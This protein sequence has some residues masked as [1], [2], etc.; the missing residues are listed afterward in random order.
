VVRCTDK[1]GAS[2]VVKASSDTEALAHE[3]AVMA[4]FAAVD[5]APEV[6]LAA[7]DLL[8]MRDMGSIELWDHPQAASAA[9]VAALVQ[10][11]HSAQIVESATPLGAGVAKLQGRVIACKE[12]DIK[13]RRMAGEAF[14][15]LAAPADR[16]LLHGDLHTKNV[17]VSEAGPRLIDPY[18]RTGPAIYDLV[19][20]SIS[21]GD[22]SRESLDELL[23]AY[24]QASDVEAWYAWTCVS[25]LE[26]A[27]RHSF[28]TAPQRERTAVAAL[29]RWR[30]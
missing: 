23:A 7:A 24:P 11:A 18:G 26:I 15:R 10:R 6:H 13:L 4:A 16:V 30:R 25:R 27:L 28:P 12:I 2:W 19:M 17:M 9:E 29:D 5:A 14:A 22:G 21:W 3:H 1:V 20:L 8:V